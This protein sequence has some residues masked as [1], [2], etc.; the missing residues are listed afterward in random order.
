MIPSPRRFLF[1][2]GPICPFFPGLALGLKA[3]GHVVH[4]I[5]VCFGDWLL[6]KGWFWPQK[7]WRAYSTK[8]IPAVDFD[9]PFSEWSDFIEDYLDRHAIT[10]VVLLGEQ[11]PYHRVAIAAA[12]QRGIA[13]TATDFGY[14]R[15]DWIIL[16][17]NGHNAL[18][19]FP[20]D[21][22]AIFDL[23]RDA[24]RLDESRGYIDSFRNQARWDVFFHVANASV[25]PFPHFQTFQL[26]PVVPAYLGTLWRLIRRGATKRRAE[27][28]MASLPEDAPFYLFAMQMETDYSI[29]AYSPYPDMDT[30]LREA[31]RSFA[32]HAPPDAHLAVKVHPLDPGLKAWNRRLARMARSAGVADRV[33]FVDALPLDALIRRAAGVVTV[34][35]T[36]GI[37][38]L[39]LATPIIALGEALYRVEGLTHEDGLDSFWKEPRQPDR[40]LTDAFLRAIARHLHVRGVFYGPEGLSAAVVAAVE[41]LEAGLPDIASVM[42]PSPP[43]ETRTPRQMWTIFRQ[44]GIGRRT[45]RTASSPADATPRADG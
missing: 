16:E 32:R 17:R 39:E 22:K 10:D 14:L 31:V 18:S 29:R 36:A 27:K 15:P 45:A 4:R 8:S 5:N 21:P 43:L 6:W 12:R 42:A 1:L 35:S 28:L 30:P 23:A 44:D 33:H 20:R 38:A 3:R 7:E 25:W 2:Q 40:V 11:R 24:P 37:R 26:H 9:R 19:G 41:R 34:N 13:V